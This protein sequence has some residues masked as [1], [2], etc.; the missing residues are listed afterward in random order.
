MAIGFVCVVVMVLV[1]T[2]WKALV[3]VMVMGLLIVG[4][5]LIGMMIG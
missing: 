5:L 1:S 2:A 4:V 3:V